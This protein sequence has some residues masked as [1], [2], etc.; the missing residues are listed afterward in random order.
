V[1][2]NARSFPL[3]TDAKIVLKRIIRVGFETW[4]ASS[5]TSNSL[6]PVRNRTIVFISAHWLIKIASFLSVIQRL[7]IGTAIDISL[8]QDYNL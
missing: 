4:N 5:V 1:A 8:I 7:R 2:K 6:D 3:S